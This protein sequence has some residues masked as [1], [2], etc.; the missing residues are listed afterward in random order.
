MKA[1]LWHEVESVTAQYHPGGSVLIVAESI[2]RAREIAVFRDWSTSAGALVD[3]KM[4]LEAEP[5]LVLQAE[6]QPEKVWVFPNA[7]CC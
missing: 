1:F 5:D 4:P 2:E 3:M 7:G 6:G